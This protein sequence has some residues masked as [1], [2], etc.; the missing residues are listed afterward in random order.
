MV[1]GDWK[2]YLEP[3]A[4]HPAA[5]IFP[6]MAERE[7]TELAKDIKE[8]RLLSPI[9][10]LG[11][12][13]LDGR[14]RLLACARA[15]VEPW[16]VQWK[17][18]GDMGPVT[19]VI[20]Q[21]LKRRHLT[22]SQAAACAVEAVPLFEAEARERRLANLK[23]GNTRP[24]VQT[25]AR[26]GE[27]KS[28]EQ[29]AGKFNTNHLYVSEAK[30]I[31]QS[32]PDLFEAIREGKKTIPQARRELGL[33]RNRITIIFDPAVPGDKK[34]FHFLAHL[35]GKTRSDTVKEILLQGMEKNESSYLPVPCSTR[36]TGQ[37]SPINPA[38]LIPTSIPGAPPDHE[39]TES[40]ESTEDERIDGEEI[41]DSIVESFIKS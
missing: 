23:R 39:L 4:W 11:T 20:S 8:N 33:E 16:L 19:W 10:L 30:A 40:Q 5:K 6:L 18:I 26:R 12:S 17:P 21:N 7:L 13:V 9:V 28:V 15:N 41:I 38:S 36:Q 34:I 3:Q 2:R 29:A 37:R 35:P 22:S 31:R 14:N 24:D 27:G 25:I 1:T 32:D